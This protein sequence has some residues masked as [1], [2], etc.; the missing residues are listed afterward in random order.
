MATPV[1]HMQIDG[2]SPIPTDPPGLPAGV[3]RELVERQGTSVPFPAPGYYCGL[4][5]GDTGSCNLLISWARRF[6]LPCLFI[7]KASFMHVPLP[8][9]VRD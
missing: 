3:P 4:V 2:R 5:G 8:L 6:L 9:S 7:F 1:D